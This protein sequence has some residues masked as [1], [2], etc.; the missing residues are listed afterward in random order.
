MAGPNCH[1]PGAS[2]GGAELPRGESRP[3]RLRKI[4]DEHQRAGKCVHYRASVGAIHHET[5]RGLRRVYALALTE[6]RRAQ[7]R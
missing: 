2:P 6:R 7:R 4:A 5:P 1:G 3:G